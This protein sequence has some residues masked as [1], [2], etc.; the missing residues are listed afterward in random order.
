MYLLGHISS[1][2][3]EPFSARSSSHIAITHIRLLTIRFLHSRGPGRQPAAATLTVSTA[4][5][6]TAT[7]TL[8]AKA[9]DETVTRVSHFQFPQPMDTI[10]VSRAVKPICVPMRGQLGALNR[11]RIE[12]QECG[13]V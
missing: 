6:T 9:T 3:E 1:I 12:T 7:R 10:R 8:V 11:A 13:I 4:E 5:V 2:A